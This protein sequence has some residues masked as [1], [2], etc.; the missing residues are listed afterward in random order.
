MSELSTTLFA[1]PSFIEGVARIW[2]FGNTL[3]EY[4]RSAG[5]NDA[6]FESMSA[7]YAAIGQ[8]ARQAIADL[9]RELALK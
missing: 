5:Q 2:D 7:D 8:D 3:N 9:R 4:N 1:N 6:N